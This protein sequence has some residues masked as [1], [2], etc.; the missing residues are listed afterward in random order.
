[1]NFNFKHYIFFIIAAVALIGILDASFLTYKHY[2]PDPINCSLI[3]GCEEV[4]TSKYSTLFGIPISIFG[5]GYYVTVLILTILITEKQRG[6]LIKYLFVLSV[7]GILVS[8]G[9]VY[10]QIGVIGSICEFCMISAA[11]TLIIFI[12][13]LVVQRKYNNNSGPLTPTLSPP[14]GER[15]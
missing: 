4:T 7:S 12:C 6:D 8:A 11:S 14:G 13:S 15:K 5:L 10:I 2:D 9:L 1:M 3:E